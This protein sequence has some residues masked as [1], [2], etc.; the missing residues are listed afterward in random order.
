MLVFTLSLGNSSAYLSKKSE[1]TLLGKTENYR[2]AWNK[3]A[4]HNLCDQ[5]VSSLGWVVKFSHLISY[6]GTIIKYNSVTFTNKQ[7]NNPRSIY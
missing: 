7:S 6:I 2:V 1:S 5:P 3:L 4:G